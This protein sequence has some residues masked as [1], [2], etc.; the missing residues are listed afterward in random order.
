MAFQV[1]SKLTNRDDLNEFSMAVAMD[2]HVVGDSVAITSG[3][4]EWDRAKRTIVW[5]LVN[6]PKGDSFMV[7][8]R[9]RVTPEGEEL[10]SGELKFPVMMR[11]KSQDQIST[12][13]FQAIEASGYPATISYSTAAQSFRLVHRLN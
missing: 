1:R 7:M 12:V 4:G 3:N 13:H 8:A 9:A 5:K 2:E 6:L 11:C 10:A